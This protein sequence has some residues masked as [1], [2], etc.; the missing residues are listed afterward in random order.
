[1]AERRNKPPGSIGSRVTTTEARITKLLSH[2]SATE[3]DP[4]ALSVGDAPPGK[5]GG[6]VAFPRTLN[7]PYG[8][9]FRALT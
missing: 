1:V 8:E 9:Q 2:R 6:G 3:K 5:V 4:V 7:Q